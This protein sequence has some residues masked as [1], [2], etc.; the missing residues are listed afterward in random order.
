MNLGIIG[1]GMIVKDF[2]SF[3]HEL[4]EINLEA[5]VARNLENLKRLSDEYLNEVNVQSL[6][7]YNHTIVLE[8]Y[9]DSWPIV[10]KY[11]EKRLLTILGDKIK[12]IEHVGS[13]SVPGLCAKPIIDILMVV[14]DSSSEDDYI[15]EL[16]S[17]GYWLKIREPEWFEHR[18]LKGPDTDINLHVFSQGASEIDK[19]LL[20]RNW[21]RENDADREL[22]AD[23]KRQLAKQIW[24]YVQNYADA[25]SQVVLEIMER[26]STK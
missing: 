18:M 24:K 23:T 6:E 1:A 19:M 14:D 22:Y 15:P 25:K 5:I 21:L 3:A 9:N 7:P 11:E 16:L 17:A 8:E 10:Y 26:A 12:C 13:T 4:P 20:F 2:L